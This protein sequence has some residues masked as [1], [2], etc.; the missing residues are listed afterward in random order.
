MSC[1][2][3]ERLAV[4]QSVV[5]V[6]PNLPR[7]LERFGTFHVHAEGCADL[8][9]GAI[10]HYAAD[11]WPMLASSRDAVVFEIHADFLAENEDSSVADYRGEVHFAPCVRLPQ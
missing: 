4:S 7:S 1:S 6:G 5:I 3:P 11:A 8:T 10:R 9:R 2:P